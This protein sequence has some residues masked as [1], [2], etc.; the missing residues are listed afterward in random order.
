M[1]NKDDVKNKLDIVDFISHYVNLKRAGRNYK[2]LCPFHKEKTPSFTVSSDRQTYKCFGCGVGGD[3]FDFY[4]RIEG[5]TFPEALKDLAIQ[6]Q[7]DLTDFN[8]DADFSQKELLIDVH[9]KATQFYQYILTN[10]PA[11]KKALEYITQ[12]GVTP[13]QIKEFQI[14]Y[15]PNSWHSLFDYL[16]KKKKLKPEDIEKAGLIIKSQS[17]Y[18]DRFRGRVM[19]P[20]KDT[21]GNIVGFSGRVVPWEDDGKTGKY[22]NSPETLIYHK[23]KMLFPLFNTKELIRNQNEVIVVEGELDALA[24][25]RASVGYVVAVKG[26]AF[27]TDQVKLLHRYADT[28]VLSLDSDK[29]GIAAAKRSIEVIEQEEINIRVVELSQGKDPDELVKTN[30]K[31][32]REIVKKAQGVYDFLLN[33]A[34]KQHDPNTIDG[35]KAISQEIVPILNKIQNQVIKDHY[36]KKLAQILQTQSLII[37]QEMQRQQKKQDLNIQSPTPS[38]PTTKS[39]LSQ[40]L[41]DLLALVLQNPKDVDYSHIPIADFPSSSAQKILEKI[42]QTKPTNIIA[43]SH[44]LPPELQEQFDTS[45]LK[46]IENMDKNELEKKCSLLCSEIAKISL[47]DKLSQLRNELAATDEEKKSVLEHQINDVLVRL[48]SYNT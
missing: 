20:L 37:E 14:G 23:S 21:R 38:P 45:Y 33:V 19:F 11:G 48:R 10:L 39:R 35:K 13:S 26:T 31:L 16:T 34:Q 18:Y 15:A 7:V 29:A 25:L 9:N 4:M 1:G 47:R 17:N 24:S 41:D 32:W 3:L 8:P 30:P 43:F 6:A 27:T 22:I 46:E 44:K 12:R 42:I 40:L 36:V 5:L 28:I 2:G